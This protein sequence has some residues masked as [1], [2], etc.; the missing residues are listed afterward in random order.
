MCVSWCK[1]YCKNVSRKKISSPTSHPTTGINGGPYR[2]ILEIDQPPNIINV[3][4]GTVGEHGPA[5]GEPEPV[6]LEPDPV[7]VLLL[8]RQPLV[9]DVRVPHRVPALRPTE[10]HSVPVRGGDPAPEELVGLRA[11]PLSVYKHVTFELQGPQGVLAW[12]VL[13][14]VCVA[15]GNLV[16]TRRLGRWVCGLVV[17]REVE[18]DCSSGGGGGVVGLVGA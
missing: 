3:G 13:G 6:A 8:D 7:L 12:R 17:R 5:A 16:Q 11:V 10:R 1:R 9:R 2:A 4:I 14:E 18:A 15:G